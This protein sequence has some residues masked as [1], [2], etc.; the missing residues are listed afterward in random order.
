M[1]RIM[2]LSHYVD[3]SKK[4]FATLVSDWDNKFGDIYMII[5]GNNNY[6]KTDLINAAGTCFFIKTWLTNNVPVITF[7]TDSSEVKIAKVNNL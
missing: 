2:F 5:F 7:S 1:L 6:T 3:F 4:N